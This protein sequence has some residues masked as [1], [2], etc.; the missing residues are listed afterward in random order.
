MSFKI[1]LFRRH[2]FNDIRIP[3]LKKDS[4]QFLYSLK[5]LQ[6]NKYA[7]NSFFHGC[8]KLS[9][10]ENLYEYARFQFCFQNDVKGLHD[11]GKLYAYYY[12]SNCSP[13]SKHNEKK[14][15]T[16]QNK[17][18]KKFTRHGFSELVSV[19]VTN[20]TRQFNSS[21]PISHSKNGII[22]NNNDPYQSIKTLILLLSVMR[23]FTLPFPPSQF[24]GSLSIIRHRK[25]CCT[26]TKL[27]E[28]HWS[29][30]WK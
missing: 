12:L 2:F 25:V 16:I 18:N 22:A 21:F 4:F 30:I 13:I 27:T 24:D 9:T 15:K 7:W 26:H 1:F 14:K 8:A 20:S 19:K 3:F 23:M 10:R 28:K 5:I 17:T 6:E 29:H 11:Q